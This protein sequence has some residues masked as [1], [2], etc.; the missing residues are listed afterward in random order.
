MVTNDSNCLVAISVPRAPQGRVTNYRRR[1]PLRAPRYAAD[2]FPFSMIH[3][4][5][6]WGH[7]AGA[8]LLR[9]ENRYDRRKL[10]P[11]NVTAR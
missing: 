11:K 9:I 7:R 8:L 6:A 1:A 2:R 5:A 3:T 4:S 10:M